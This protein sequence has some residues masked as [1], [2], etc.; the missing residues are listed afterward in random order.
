MARPLEFEYV[1][2]CQDPEAE[3]EKLL[4]AP[5]SPRA[6]EILAE[7]DTLYNERQKASRA[8]FRV[9]TESWTEVAR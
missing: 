8:P 6:M 7:A 1:I 2:E 3:R 4:S 9:A 5:A